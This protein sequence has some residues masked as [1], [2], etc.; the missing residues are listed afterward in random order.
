MQNTLQPVLVLLA[1]AVLVVVIFRTLK[2]P[3][4]LGYLIV[5]GRGAADRLLF[6]VAEQ[7]QAK[8]WPLAG[9]VQVND[10]RDPQARCD[11]DLHVLARDRVVRISQ[12]LGAL[13]RGCRLDPAALASAVGLAEAA[14]TSSPRLCIVNKFGKAEVDGAG[15]RPLIGAAMAQGIPVLTS[16]SRGNLEAFLRFA[17]GLGEE[18][19]PN[20]T[21]VLD[22]CHRHC[23]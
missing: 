22:W 14:L 16:V 2:L 17:E 20:P 15:F 7:L 8:G 21:A 19:D 11:M 13:S 1:A 4:L 3:P 6:S 23:G 18:I 12:N 9:A 10:E 5:E